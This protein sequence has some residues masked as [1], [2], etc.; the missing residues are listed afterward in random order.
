MTGKELPVATVFITSCPWASEFLHWNCKRHISQHIKILGFT[1]DNINSYL[2]STIL[3]DP[4]LLAD[5]KKYM[6]CYPQIDSM[7]YIPLNS[8]IVVEVYRNSRKDETLYSV[9]CQLSSPMLVRSVA[10]PRNGFRI[11]DMHQNTVYYVRFT[12]NQSLNTSVLPHLAGFLRVQSC[13]DQ[14]SS[15]CI[16][17]HINYRHSLNNPAGRTSQ[18]AA[19]IY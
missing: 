9:T 13:R 1:K 15:L 19:K 18:K 6:S 16:T 4:S 5:L 10:S 2:K 17:S 7:M 14:L 3:N 12:V 11:S 8:A